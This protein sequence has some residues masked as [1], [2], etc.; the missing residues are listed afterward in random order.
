[1]KK[2]I[3]AVMALALLLSL[4]GCGS[5]PEPPTEPVTAAPTEPPPQMHTVAPTAAEPEPEWAPVDCDISLESDGETV[6]DSSGFEYFAIVGSE[7]DSMLSFKLSE[8]SSK[9]L[10]SRGEDSV[11][12]LVLNG[13]EIGS[14]VPDESYEELILD[15]KLPYEYLCE[16]ATSIR[17]VDTF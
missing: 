15:E 8:L 3:A 5:A 10:K 6:V 13:K 2:I 16:L 17:G 7:D 11:Y 14:A 12:T 4:V 1:M 9:L